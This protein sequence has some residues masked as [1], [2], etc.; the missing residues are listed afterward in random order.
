MIGI[1]IRCR[2]IGIIFLLFFDIEGLILIIKKQ[3]GLKSANQIMEETKEVSSIVLFDGVCNFCDS[4]VRFVIDHD[5][6]NRYQFASQQSVIGQQLLLQHQAPSDTSTIVLIKDSK[7]YLRSTA[8][9]KI[10]RHLRSPWNWL[11][12]FIYVPK[13][14]REWAYN[15]FA[16]NRYRWFG[17]KEFCDIPEPN[18]PAKFL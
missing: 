2:S 9:L 6:N 3:F 17:T 15:M 10:A 1:R 16:K 11:Y 8:M 14:I 4:T 18:I 7:V 5:S 13:P 12:V